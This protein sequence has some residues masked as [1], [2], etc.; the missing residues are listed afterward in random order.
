MEDHRSG[1]SGAA[2]HAGVRGVR[3]R[4]DAWRRGDAGR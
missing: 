1:D 2:V 3:E 4:G